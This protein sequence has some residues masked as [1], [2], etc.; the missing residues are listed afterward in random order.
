MRSAVCTFEVVAPPISSG[1]VKPC[2][3]ISSAT[4]TISSSDGV[5]RPLRPIMSA[6]LSLARLQDVLERHHDAEIDDLEIVA[7]QDHAD[8]VLADVVDVALDRGHDD[9]ALGPRR[10]RS[11]RASM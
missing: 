8:D 4:V 3:V 11:S 10:P 9:L 1:S 7:L 6:L 2:R 5:I